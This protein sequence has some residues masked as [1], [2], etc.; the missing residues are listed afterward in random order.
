MV[1]WAIIMS[2]IIGNHKRWL[3]TCLESKERVVQDEKKYATIP[4]ALQEE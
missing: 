1:L 3:A 2:I 4:S